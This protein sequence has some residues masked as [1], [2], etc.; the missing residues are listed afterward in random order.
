MH[1][2]PVC[3]AALTGGKGNLLLGDRIDRALQSMNDGQ[4]HGIPIGPDLCFVAAE[5]LLAAVDQE[6]LNRCKSLI[7]GFRYVDDFEL[8]F[9]SLSDAE[10]LLSELQ[11][12]MTD[13]EL[14]LNP[15]KTRIDDLPK[16]IESNWGTE[17]SR[18]RIRDS[19]SP[20]GQRNDVVALFSRAYEIAS[21]FPEES[22]LKYAVSRVQNLGV[23]SAAWHAFHNCVLGAACADP[24]T[25]AVSLGT[26]HQTAATGKHSVFKA[27]LAETFESVI[28]RHAP[29]G[30]GSEV[31]WALWGALAWSVPLGATA[32]QLVG[33][34][35]DGIVALLALDADAR[36]LFPVGALDK[37]RWSAATA[38]PGV[39]T[40]EDWL[41]A[42][43]A[44]QQN[45]L[46]CPAV[47]ADPIFSKMSTAG[48][49][50][51]DRN[52]NSPQFPTAARAIPG[53][54]LADHY[55]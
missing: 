10:N 31:A 29:R 34:M 19:N 6:L 7:R 49:S 14:M 25:M 2:K 22:V 33:R 54:V 20:T 3:K 38:Q 32:A 51:Y 16:A 27:P 18:F 9:G 24:S 43:E 11:S 37:S 21:Q 13:Y 44:N 8:T 17:L 36:G 15:R 52:L 39:L 42:Y 12:I 23:H 35:D 26:L 4:T 45:W 40:S 48:I 55:A 53:G 46:S 30:E 47:A 41:L 28:I 50:F 5:V 1:T